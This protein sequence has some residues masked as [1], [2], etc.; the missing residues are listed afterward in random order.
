MKAPLGAEVGL[1]YDGRPVSVEDC[2]VTPSGRVYFIISLRV[3][4][5]GIH[6]G[7][8]HIRAIVMDQV[9]ERS[10]AHPIYWYKRG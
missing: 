2:L 9:P 10:K 1:Y 3:Q 6:I 5:R 4:E 8:Q 7:R